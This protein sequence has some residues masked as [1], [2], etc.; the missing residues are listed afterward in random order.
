LKKQIELLHEEL[1]VEESR[2]QDLIA[3]KE[4]VQ[5]EMSNLERRRD[6]LIETLQ[7]RLAIMNQIQESLQ[8]G[9]AVK[10]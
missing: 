1:T 5:V 6:D 2:L 4:A 10:L 9:L 3:K 8:E 7:S